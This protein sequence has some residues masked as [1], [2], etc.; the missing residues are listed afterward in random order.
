MKNKRIL[1]FIAFIVLVVASIL[2]LGKDMFSPYVSFSYAKN[3]P[4]KYVQVIGKRGS[5]VPANTEGKGYTFTLISEKNEQMNAWTTEAKP[6][7]FE[8]AEELV[9]IGRYS[10]EKN[11]FIA[12]KVLTKCPSKYQKEKK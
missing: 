11:I 1:V 3:H 10:K 12:D 9:V 2:L 6:A 4:D 7:N 5:V 8:H